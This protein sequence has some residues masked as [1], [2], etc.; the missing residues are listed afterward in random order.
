MI[1]WSFAP[2]SASCVPTVCRNLSAETVPRCLPRQP[3]G[4][5]SPAALL[6]A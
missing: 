1:V 5:I 4:L 2:R 6:A 3:V